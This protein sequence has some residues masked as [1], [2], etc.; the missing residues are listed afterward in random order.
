MTVE[1]NSLVHHLGVAV[2][3][4]D[5]EGRIE[6]CNHMVA[7]MLGQRFDELKGTSLS[8]RLLPLPGYEEVWETEIGKFEEEGVQSFDALLTRIDRAP[9]PVRVH[10]SSYVETP[11][12]QP[13]KLYALTDIP[14][15]SAFEDRKTKF[16]RALGHEINSPLTML[17]LAVDMSGSSRPLRTSPDEIARLL[18]IGSQRVSRLVTLM[19]TT[20]KLHETMA[21]LDREPVALA[22]LLAAL[23]QSFE[24]EAEGR[25]IRLELHDVDEVV[26]ADRGTLKFIFT[27]L[28]EHALRLASRGTVLRVTTEKIP[29]KVGVHIEVAGVPDGPPQDSRAHDSALTGYEKRRGRTDMALDICRWLMELHDG[30]LL[31]EESAAEDL[32]ITVTLPEY[33]DSESD[34]ESTWESDVW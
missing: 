21:E 17:S 20:V 2:V 9:R 15:P 19:V 4:E 34:L 11:G 6:Y 10:L 30:D 16:L 14:E 5:M 12:E 25:G 29:A 7:D 18:R 27:A 26:L 32:S 13:R 33:E 22:P 31:D 3:V 24:L 28:L 23:I 8:N 1:S